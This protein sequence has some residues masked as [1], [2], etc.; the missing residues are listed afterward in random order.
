MHY[1]RS[2]RAVVGI[3]FVFV[4]AVVIMIR[5]SPFHLPLKLNLVV[6][7]VAVVSSIGPSAT[8][9]DAFPR[10]FFGWLRKLRIAALIQSVIFRTASADCARDVAATVPPHLS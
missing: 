7:V 10:D 1:R 9:H 3:V 4:D 6:A 5:Y 2:L 8:V